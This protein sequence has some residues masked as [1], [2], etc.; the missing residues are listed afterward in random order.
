MKLLDIIKRLP[1]SIASGD[2]DCKITHITCDSRE[3]QEGSI[4]VAIRGTES[5]GHVYIKEALQAGA[6]AIVAERAPDSDWA[7]AVAW[8][9]TPDSRRT[10]SKLADMLADRPSAKLRVA[11]ITG[12]NGKTTTTFLLHHILQTV[13]RRAGMLGTV[14]TN[15]G[16][17]TQAATH[18]TPEAT[19]LHGFLKSIIENDCRSVVMEVSSHGIEQCRVDSVQF[20]VAVFTN[21]TQDHLDYHKTM[22]AYYEAK[23]LLFT[24]LREQGGKKKPVGVINSDDAWGQKLIKDLDGSL[25][26]ITFGAGAHCDFRLGK[27]TQTIRTCEFELIAKGKSYL[28]RMP[29]F[30]RY[31][32]YN[33]IGA[34]AAATT[35][36]VRIRDAVRAVMETP[37]VPGRLEWIA[38]DEGVNVFVDYAHTPDA[39]ENVCA[40]L[41]E[42]DPKRLITVFGCG[43]DRDKGKRPLM[44]QSASTNSDL[45]FV[46]SD[47]PRSEDPAMIIADIEPG[48]SSCPYRAIPDRKEAIMAA[49][50]LATAGDVVLIAG[51][52]HEAYQE[53]QGEKIEFDDRKV[54]ME[55]VRTRPLPDRVVRQREAEARK[56]TEAY[57]RRRASRDE[58]PSLGEKSEGEG[59][60]EFKERDDRGGERREFK[61]RDDRGGER[62]EF[63]GRDD[64]RGGERREFK[65]GER[66]EFKG[67]D[68]RRGGERREF[69]GRD[70]RREQAELT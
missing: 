43:G 56:K 38:S 41:H 8:V 31:N 52:G 6:I 32:V 35:M 55:A 17:E 21:L 51:K 42:L 39:L 68:D 16:L 7:E 12:T 67:R 64:R 37:Q 59:R 20:D 13:Q 62:R 9:H 25:P 70:D 19:Q 2:L 48:M 40:T 58:E 53:I 69:K 45:C 4:F 18:T 65:G 28:V 66:R 11:G 23:K 15:D 47:N 57:E 63:K 46:T 44:G 1:G 10:L 49:V 3:V 54:A 29:I 30:G 61:G 27:F 22:E 36:G 24:G 26:L 60:R 5:D 50:H 33:A 34:I 14:W